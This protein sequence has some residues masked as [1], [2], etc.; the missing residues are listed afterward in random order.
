M[1]GVALLLPEV[2]YGKKK[3]KTAACKWWRPHGGAVGR[4]FKKT[5]WGFCYFQ[6]IYLFNYLF[7]AAP[8]V[9]GGS[10]AK[11]SRRKLYSWKYQRRDFTS[12]P[13]SCAVTSALLLPSEAGTHLPSPLAS[14]LLFLLFSLPLWHIVTSQLCRR[15]ICWS[16]ITGGKHFL[17]T[18]LI[19]MQLHR[20]RFQHWNLKHPSC[21]TPRI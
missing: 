20:W 1:L 17:L 13:D 2:F 6:M 3:K 16:L 21:Q 5:L 8:Q 14:L 18:L 4:I 19:V 11:H 9:R 10:A 12:L 15:K 7:N